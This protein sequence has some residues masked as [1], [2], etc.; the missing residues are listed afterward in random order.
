MAKSKLSS[1]MSAR[2]KL[3]L[4]KMETSSFETAA[5]A[6]LDGDE[7]VQSIPL[8]TPSLG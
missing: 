7:H 3:G 1:R 6:D 8:M 4:L 5:C 2:G